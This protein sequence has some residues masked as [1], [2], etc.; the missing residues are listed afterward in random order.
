MLTREQFE[1]RLIQHAGEIRRHITRRIPRHLSAVIGP[2]DILQDVWKAALQSA[3]HR[4]EIDLSS[5]DSWLIRLANNRL[6]DVI[7]RHRAVRRAQDPRGSGR[8]SIQD[9]LVLTQGIGRSPSSEAALNER[10]S[11]VLNALDL[12]PDE[13]NRAIRLR[14]LHGASIEKIAIDMNRTEGSIRGLL[15]RGL[16]RLRKSQGSSAMEPIPQR[17][18]FDH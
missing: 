4:K 15:A 7:R 10:A 16:R 11:W 2:D 13:Q 14:Y 5:M 18:Q 1:R 17:R 8:T 3:H 12:L 9:L 6:I